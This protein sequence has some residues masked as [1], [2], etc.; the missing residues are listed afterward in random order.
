[1]WYLTGYKNCNRLVRVTFL[2]HKASCACLTKQGLQ[3]IRF[4]V[5]PVSSLLQYLYEYLHV[6]LSVASFCTYYLHIL[7]LCF[8]SR[9]LS[10]DRLQQ[11][12][13]AQAAA[14][15]NRQSI[16]EAARR[17]EEPHIGDR[18][19]LFVFTISMAMQTCLAGRLSLNSST[20]T[21]FLVQFY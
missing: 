17:N 20:Q 14:A 3:P 19:F 1:M 16:V 13:S 6:S 12:I 7:Y 21:A 11:R 9:L 18:L 10:Y 4:A 2:G 8:S 15:V 5:A